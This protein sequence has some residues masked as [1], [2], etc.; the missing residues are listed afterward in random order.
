MRSIF[1]PEMP[2]RVEG[3]DGTEHYMVGGNWTLDDTGVSWHSG[4]THHF[5]PLTSVIAIHQDD[6]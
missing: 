3:L 1:D 6:E 2:L 4:A 5:L